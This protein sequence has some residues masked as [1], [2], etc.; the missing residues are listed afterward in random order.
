VRTAASRGIGVFVPEGRF[1]V[2]E[3]R[4]LNGL[5]FIEGPGWLVG[6][7]AGPEG[8]LTT[9]DLG[10][11]SP[12]SGLRISANIDC[13][14]TA[15]RGI[16]CVGLRDSQIMNSHV[17]NLAHNGGD[18]IRLNF[19]GSANNVISRNLVEL[20]T[21]TPYE[22]L[23]E[24]LFGI[25]VVGET[26]SPYGGIE[27]HHG[28]I[29]P[30]GTTR[31]NRV[32]GNTVRGGTHGIIF[33]GAVGFECRQNLCSDQMARNIIASATSL[34]GI[35][36]DNQCLGAGSAA[37]HASFGCRRIR[38][39]NN[40]IRSETVQRRE[41]DDSAIQVYCNCTNVW[42]GG[43]DIA[44]D[45]RHGIYVAY[46]SDVDI[47]D[48]RIDATQ[49][50]SATIMVENAWSPDSPPAGAIYSWSRAIR[51][52]MDMDTRNIRMRGNRISGGLAAIVLTQIGPRPLSDIRIEG[53]SIAGSRQ[54]DV[55]AFEQVPG[56]LRDIQLQD[57]DIERGR[58]RYLLPRGRAHFS[59]VENVPGF[60]P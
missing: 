4:L 33:F 17:K 60:A 54:Y 46:A 48:N 14:R 24:G 3:V 7:S 19:P 21:D 20:S 58:G 43:N 42:I 49:F 57:V 1:E 44:G 30:I 8:V 47:V 13:N 52:D 35:I 22:Q 38:I 2:R 25:H 51:F 36:S 59:K 15:R 50:A 23:S 16:F 56:N 12:V 34:D 5:K 9:N 28:P 55:F 6:T 27:Q 45:W 31:D 26:A 40:V 10:S 39:V 32:I 18:A 29:F 41:D 37:V 11:L 53:G